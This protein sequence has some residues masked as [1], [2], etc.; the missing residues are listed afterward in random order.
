MCFGVP[1]E[2]IRESS[3]Y[4]TIKNRCGGKFHP[5]LVNLVKVKQKQNSLVI[6]TEYVSSEKNLK[7]AFET[8]S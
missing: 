8:E 4:S 2:A 3:V 1:T 5:N 6:I 7:L